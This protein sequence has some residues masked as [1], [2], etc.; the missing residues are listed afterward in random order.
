VKNKSFL[1]SAIVLILTWS[2]TLL[3]FQNEE[4]ALKYFAII[5]FLPMIVAFIFQKF[6][7]LKLQQ[8]IDIFTFKNLKPQAMLLGIFLPIVVVLIVAILNISFSI[9]SFNAASLNNPGKI[10]ALFA[11]FIP[12]LLSVLGEEIGWRGYLLPSLA[13]KYT[14]IKATVI[15]GIVWALFHLPV[16]YLLA[17]VEKVPNPGVVALVQAGTVFVISFAFAYIFFLSRNLIPVI[18][19]HAI[20]NEFNPFVLGNLYKNEPG[21]LKGDI[22][23]QNGEGVMGLIVM[24]VIGVFFIY[25]ISSMKENKSTHSLML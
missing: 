22:F 1:F 11:T 13:E 6:P 9:S 21:I 14:K 2:V 5:M 18:L 10:T 17:K 20:W 23:V 12:A 8:G 24:T 4:L 3:L 7:T 15:T 25:K 19:F 16:V